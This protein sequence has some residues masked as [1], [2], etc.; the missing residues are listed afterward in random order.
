MK[1][2]I[3]GIL[4]VMLLIGTTISVVGIQNKINDR[5]KSLSSDEVVWSMT[6]GYSKFDMLHCVHLT[7]DGGYIACGTTEAEDLDNIYRPWILRVD[8]N[9]NKLWDWILTEIE[10]EGHYFNM[11]DECWC[12]YVIEVSDGGFVSC[13]RL[14]CTTSESDSYWICG[15]L[16]LDVSGNLQWIEFCVDGFDWSFSPYSLIE[17]DDGSLIATGMS[18]AAKVDDPDDLAC[19]YKTDANGVEQWRKEYKY[20]D[21]N[22]DAWGI[23]ETN[24]G[25]YLMTGCAGGETDGNYWMIKTDNEGGLDWEKTYGGDEYDFCQT[26]N[27]YQTTDGGYIMSGYSYSFGNGPLDVWIVKTDNS[28]K[29]IWNRT[30]GGSNKDTSWSF[31]S[32]NG[33]FVFCIAYNYA[34]FGNKDDIHLVKTDNNGNIDWVI[35]HEEEGIQTGQY[36]DK[37]NDGG[38]IVSGRTGKWLSDKSD[39]LIIKFMSLENQRPNKPDTPDGSS[40]GKPD[41]E[42]TFSTSATDP[43]GDALQYMWDWGD[44]NYSEWLDSNEAS[45]TWSYEDNFEIRVMAMDEHGG[46]SD[47]SDP[48]AFSTPKNKAVNL[49]QLNVLHPKDGVLYI[50]DTPIQILPRG[51]IVIGKI[52]V[53]ASAISLQI[54]DKIEFYVDDVLRH[55]EENRLSWLYVPWIWDDTIFFKHTLKVVAYDKG[56][57][58]ASEEIDVWIFNI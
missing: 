1:K 15:L 23:C 39:G 47:W 40:K 46:E 32:F 30:Y 2:K 34:S 26:R 50:Q 52:T 35:K 37:T 27:C 44:G 17:L 48:L 16:K 33:G 7:D 11:F 10:Y 6:Y 14:L 4:V 55:T 22:D 53:V 57:N 24:D 36:I 58:I 18:G 20:S 51:T 5:S 56:E 38:F 45:Y 43:D 41:I 49:V 25:G 28:G 31:A 21:F 3:I 54:M 12:T 29:M 9:G 13:F 19:L 42:Y 8:A